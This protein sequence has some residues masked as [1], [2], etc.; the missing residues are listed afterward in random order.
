MHSSACFIHYE[1]GLTALDSCLPETL[2]LSG[3]LFNT[4]MALGLINVGSLFETI[5]GAV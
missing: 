2:R 3:A 1:E 5:V 4:A